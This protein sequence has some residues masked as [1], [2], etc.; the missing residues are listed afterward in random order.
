MEKTSYFYVLY[1]RDGSLYGGFTVDLA[2]RLKE[3]NEGKGAKYT[4][5]G[6][7]RPLKMIYAEMYA[8]KGEALKAEAHFKKKARPEK[9]AFLQHQGVRFP[10]GSGAFILN[11]EHRENV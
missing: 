10:L 9:E 11:T 8:T 6:S 4:R 2:R 5:A 3:H 1:C 7:R